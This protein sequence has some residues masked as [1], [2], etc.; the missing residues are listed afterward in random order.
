MKF[1]VELEIP[2]TTTVDLIVEANSEEQAKLRGLDY[3]GES[4]EFVEE[5]GEESESSDQEF[6][7]RKVVRVSRVE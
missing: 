7:E 5:A 3:L 1:I 4:S 2:S 6:G